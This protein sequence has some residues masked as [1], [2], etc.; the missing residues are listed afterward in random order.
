[1]ETPEDVL[2]VCSSLVNPHKYDFHSLFMTLLPYIKTERA[3]SFFVS[4]FAPNF[5]DYYQYIYFM[6]GH[7]ETPPVLPISNEAWELLLKKHPKYIDHVPF[8]ATK[9]VY[10]NCSWMSREQKGVVSTIWRAHADVHAEHTPATVAMTLYSGSVVHAYNI[11]R[12]ML[13]SVFVGVMHP[14]LIPFRDF[15]ST[16]LRLCDSIPS[17]VSAFKQNNLVDLLE[18]LHVDSAE[19]ELVCAFARH[20]VDKIAELLN[21]DD[22]VEPDVYFMSPAIA[23]ELNHY[24]PVSDV[25]LEKDTP[26]IRLL[27]SYD[28]KF[29]VSDEYVIE[30]TDAVLDAARVSCAIDK[31]T[32]ELII[33]SEKRTIVELREWFNNIPISHSAFEYLGIEVD[34]GVVDVI[35]QGNIGMGMRRFSARSEKRTEI[36]DEPLEFERSQEY[37]ILK[38]LINA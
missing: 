33:T 4:R 32:L 14:D 17:I 15:V 11:K 26:L 29:N 10:N 6:G 27:L 22:L 5:S 13:E 24:C 21:G 1:M 19:S 31:D 28:L 25:H 18:H 34:K 2:D 8:E 7:N 35:T 12:D 23:K 16:Q 30:H 38:K 36:L 20:K 3:M 9:Y 37:N